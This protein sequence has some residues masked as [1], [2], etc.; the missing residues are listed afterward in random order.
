MSE[1]C[2][3]NTGAQRAGQNAVKARAHEER[4]SLDAFD[5]VPGD[6]FSLK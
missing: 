3:N 1:E 4:P 2:D 5:G 6:L